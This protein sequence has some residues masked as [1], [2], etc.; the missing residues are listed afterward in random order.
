MKKSIMIGVQMRGNDVE[1][2]CQDKD[3]E[4]ELVKMAHMYRCKCGHWIFEKFG[5]ITIIGCLRCHR[6]LVLVKEEFIKKWKA[7]YIKKWLVRRF[8]MRGN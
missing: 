4:V 1:V 5:D 3:L 8:G 6:G 2:V 7:G